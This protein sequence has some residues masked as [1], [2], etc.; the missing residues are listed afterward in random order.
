[1]KSGFYIVRTLAEEPDSGEGD[2]AV[3]ILAHAKAGRFVGVDQGGCKFT[4]TYETGSDGTTVVRLSYAFKAGSSLPNGIVLEQDTT[5][6]SEFTLAADAS[7]GVPQFVDIG[8]GPLHV[9]LEWLA[10]PA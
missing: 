4:G 10:D 3:A 9:R 8:I 1:M 5:I 2:G 7:D 6:P